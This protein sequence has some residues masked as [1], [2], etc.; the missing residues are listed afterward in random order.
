MPT[1][2]KEA[3]EIRAWRKAHGMCVRCGKE[4]AVSGHTTCLIC[5]MDQREKSRERS[6]RHRE[7]MTEEERR[8]RN[9][10]RRLR[11]A[12]RKKL[13]LC[14]QCMKPVYKNHAYCYTHYISQ[15]NAHRRE[16][17]KKYAYH[18]SGTCRICG[19]EPEP[20]HKMCPVHY[21][22]YSDRMIKY[23]KDRSE[24]K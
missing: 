2:A 19:C 20:G 24:E 1:T 14:R 5:M 13:G 17:K 10:K 18:P 23:N 9:E 16:R 8:V 3:R 22:E 4:K 15:K 21:K 12:E 11:S 7:S 6:R